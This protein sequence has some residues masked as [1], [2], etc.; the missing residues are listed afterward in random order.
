ME[1]FKIQKDGRWYRLI[2][3][4]TCWSGG[5]L[6]ELQKYQ[7]NGW[8]KYIHSFPTVENAKEYINNL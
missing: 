1:V 8:W 7:D 3:P 6:Y 5:C 4:S 2:I